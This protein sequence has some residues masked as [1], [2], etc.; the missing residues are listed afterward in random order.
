MF[1]KLVATLL[2]RFLGKY[3]T[4][5]DAKNL[6]IGL[7][8]GEVVLRNLEVID[9]AFDQFNL[10]LSVLRGFFFFVV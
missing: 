9:S 10:P 3:V 5:F 8:S 6:K 2:D 7:V 1:E 4:N